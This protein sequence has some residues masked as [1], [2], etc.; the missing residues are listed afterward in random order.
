MFNEKRGQKTPKL[1]LSW[2]P[3]FEK[4]ERKLYDILSLWLKSWKNVPLGKVWNFFDR[5]IFDDT[6]SVKLIPFEGNSIDTWDQNVLANSCQSKKIFIRNRGH[7]LTVISN[8]W[9]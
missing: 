2:N 4:K 8:S 7:T 6:L 9:M 5:S 3:Q 1:N